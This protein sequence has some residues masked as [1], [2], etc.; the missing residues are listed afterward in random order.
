M[1]LSQRYHGS[2]GSP[3]YMV[4]EPPLGHSGAPW[5]PGGECF[6]PCFTI[7]KI[8][9]HDQ[10]T[11]TVQKPGNVRFCPSSYRCFASKLTKPE[12]SASHH[13]SPRSVPGLEDSASHHIDF[14]VIFSPRETSRT[15]SESADLSRCVLTTPSGRFTF[16]KWFPLGVVWTNSI[17]LDKTKH[18]STNTL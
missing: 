4:E 5:K 11:L 16:L 9:K 1:N 2:K 13:W 15:H 10:K 12:E 17:S 8:D 7:I 18:S 6:A 3:D 14:L